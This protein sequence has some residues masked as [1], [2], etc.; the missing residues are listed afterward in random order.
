V[1]T[2]SLV[3]GLQIAIPFAAFAAVI[4]GG[5][6]SVFCRLLGLRRRPFRFGRRNRP[7][8]PSIKG[9]A[10]LV[11]MRV[12]AVATAKAHSRPTRRPGSL[13]RQG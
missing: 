3:V 11:P 4:L 8:T 7:A 1:T 9:T 6:S 12:T 10:A 5:A 13:A 2:E